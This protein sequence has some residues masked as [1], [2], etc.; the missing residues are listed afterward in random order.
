M[1]VSQTGGVREGKEKF[2]VV[3]KKKMIRASAKA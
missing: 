3:S 1:R 2:F